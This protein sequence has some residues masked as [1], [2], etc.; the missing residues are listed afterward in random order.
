LKSKICYS[1]LGCFSGVF[2]PHAPEYIGTNLRLYTRKNPKSAQ[3]LQYD[4]DETI[5]DSNF[6]SSLK[7]IFITHGWTG[8]C[9]SHTNHLSFNIQMYQEHRLAIL[10]KENA[11]VICVDWAQG[12]SKHYL[13]AA[14]NTAMVG[15]QIALMIRAMEK[16]FGD[17]ISS[18]I[19]LVGFSLGAHVM[20]MAGHYLRGKL[21]RIT[22]L[23]P[24]GPFFSNKNSALDKDDAKYVDVIHTNA[25]G[26][27][28][29]E[30]IGHADFYV[31][32]GDF[33]PGCNDIFCS[34]QRAQEFFLES[35]RSNCTF[36]ACPC[37][38]DTLWNSGLCSP[39]KERF[40]GMGYNFDR[41]TA[42]G[43]FYLTTSNQKPYCIK[44]SNL[45]T[46]EIANIG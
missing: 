44:N 38:T 35:I 32:G 24:A 36:T 30:A 46:P 26:A 5:K 22:G 21:H 29:S 37:E 13:Q 43:K 31:N 1:V 34:H 20:G 12:A 11:N 18:R 41:F 8:S 17:D 39:C 2:L 33:Q 27:G 40:I 14:S 4:N 28:L 15:K 16:S 9:D 23:D 25:G 7:T 10:D 19:H 6:N 3:I 45:V 42:P